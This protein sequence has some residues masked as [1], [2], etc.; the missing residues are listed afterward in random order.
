MDTLPKL[1]HLNYAHMCAFV[2]GRPRTSLANLTDVWFRRPSGNFT[3]LAS[4]FLTKA[5]EGLMRFVRCSSRLRPSWIVWHSSLSSPHLHTPDEPWRLV[6][7]S[8][9]PRCSCWHLFQCLHLLRWPRQQLVL[10]LRQLHFVQ[11]TDSSSV[12]PHSRW[13]Q[14]T[15]SRSHPHHLPFYID[16]CLLCLRARRS[17]SLHH[18][19]SR[20]LTNICTNSVAGV[21]RVSHWLMHSKTARVHPYLF[22][23]SCMLVIQGSRRKVI[24]LYVPQERKILLLL[25]PIFFFD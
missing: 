10:F 23:W 5:S 16:E 8:S 22:T 20:L 14:S 25:S 11:V 15:C 9:R 13:N 17:K 7:L 4:W 12:N 1:M 19:T 18:Q 24:I 21:S 3:W 2:C 6:T